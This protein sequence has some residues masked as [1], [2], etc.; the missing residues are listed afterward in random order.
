MN[1]GL[2]NE[3]CHRGT[4][5]DDQAA[6]E[7]LRE[8]HRPGNRTTRESRDRPQSGVRGELAPLLLEPEALREDYRQLFRWWGEG[9]L[10]PHVGATFPLDEAGD[11]LNA[12]LSRKVA[13]KIVLEI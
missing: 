13:G 8:P 5:P 6:G 7:E 2:G 10:K 12:L 1:R 9:K 11:A 3:P 4:E